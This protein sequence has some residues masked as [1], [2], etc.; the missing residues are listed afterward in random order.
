LTEVFDFG[1]YANYKS[2]LEKMVAEFKGYGDDFY[3]ANI[4][5]R[6]LYSIKLLFDAEKPIQHFMETP[7]WQDKLLTTGL[8]TW[9]ELRHDTILYNEPV[10]AWGSGGGPKE[11]PVIP[12][13]VGYVEPHSQLYQALQKTVVELHDQL[14]DRHLWFGDYR[15]GNEYDG[16]KT[17]E[18]TYQT[19]L[20]TLDYLNSINDKEFAGQGLSA[21]EREFIKEFGAYLEKI[22][23]NLIN[24]DQ[25]AAHSSDGG[26]KIDNQRVALVADVASGSAP[27]IPPKF[28]LEGV[29]DP[30]TMVAVV[31]LAGKQQ[32]CTGGVYLHYEFENDKPMN[33][34]EWRALLDSS[35]PPQPGPW[36]DS[37]LVYPQVK[38]L[39]E[40]LNLRSL[41]DIESDKVGT[42]KKDEWVYSLGTE[43]E[44]YYDDPS[45]ETYH[46]CWLK[47][48]DGAGTTGWLCYMRENWFEEH[49]NEFYAQLSSSPLLDYSQ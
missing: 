42:V 48:K 10:G 39:A 34:T 13:V 4:Y 41:P 31:N 27:G 35:N 21:E 17:L 20:T 46:Y 26:A 32:L 38:V 47:V 8:A 45:G 16:F 28:L 3:S 15:Q 11:Y 12:E 19:I 36:M 5:N 37:Y 2:Q 22:T 40:A 9:T 1:R 29:G 49:K 33:D 44:Q 43:E 23:L 30:S 14:L 24:Y 7:A 25:E 6:W 18:E